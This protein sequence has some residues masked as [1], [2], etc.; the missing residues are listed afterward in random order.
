[1]LQVQN[2]FAHSV[3]SFFPSF[4]LTCCLFLPTSFVGKGPHLRRWLVAQPLSMVSYSV[5]FFSCNVNARRCGHSSVIL[6]SD[7]RDWCDSSCQWPLARNL[8]RNC[9]P[10]YRIL[11][12]NDINFNLIMWNLFYLIIIGFASGIIL[13]ILTI[14][15]VKKATNSY[16]IR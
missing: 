6:I 13:L 11:T 1:M 3:L 5:I 16:Q 9:N 2:V 7:R 12:R 10:Q 8:D 4:S 14:I 15:I